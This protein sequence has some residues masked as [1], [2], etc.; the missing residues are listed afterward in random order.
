M[1][2]N[3]L[4]NENKLVNV[5]LG[6]VTTNGG[7][8]TDVVSLKNAIRATF[9]VDLTQAVGHATV[10]SLKQATDVAAGTNAAGPVSQIWMNED[11]AT[12]DT[13]VKQT[14]AASVTV[15]NNIKKKQI[16][17]EVDPAALTDTYDC[18]YLTVGDSSQATN[19]ANANVI[20]RANFQRATPPAA[21]TD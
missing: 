17:I 16:V 20:I 15:T 9:V 1:A 2:W 10:V 7:I 8:T 5:S 3:S 21:I 4:A 14:D 12:S 18:V 13:L 6:P 19:Y 11:V